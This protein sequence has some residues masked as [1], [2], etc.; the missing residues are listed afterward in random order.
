MF[1]AM[2]KGWTDPRYYTFKQIDQMDGCYV[3]AG[4]K[5]TPIEYWYVY[6]MK[7]K[8]GMTFSEYEQLRKDDPDR[9]DSEF[10]ISTRSMY[11]FNAAQVEG[12]EP[13]KHSLPPFS[14]F[15]YIIQKKG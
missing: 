15:Y 6:D 9:K 2:D 4:E 14:V 12:L 11:V 7:E 8:R 3:R 1:Q 10:R 13:L 5:A